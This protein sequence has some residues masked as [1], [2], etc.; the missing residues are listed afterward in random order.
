MMKKL[1]LLLLFSSALFAYAQEEDVFDEDLLDL[2]LEELLNVQLDVSKT[3][4]SLRETPAIIS[5]I[6]RQEIANSGA[7]DLMDVLNLVPGFSFGVDVQNTIGL[8]L[9]GNWGHEGKILL[10]IDGMEMNETLFSTTQF[11]QHYNVNNIERIEIIRGPGSSIYGGYAELGV[12][13][14]ITRKG[15]DIE[16][17]RVTGMYGFGEGGTYRQVGSFSLGKSFSSGSFSLYGDY[18]SAQRSISDY[19]DA[20]GA[21]TNLTDQ[22]RLRPAS[23]GGSLILGDLSANFLYDNYALETVDQFGDIEPMDVVSFRTFYSNIKYKKEINEKLTVT[24]A[25]N[26]KSGI[27]WGVDIATP[28]GW[29]SDDY[30]VYYHIQT[31]RLAPSLLVN[32]TISENADLLIGA[33]SYFDNATATTDD[34]STDYFGDSNSVKYS[35]IGAFAQSVIKTDFAN[36][37]L[38]ARVDN[39][40]AVGSAFS[41]RIGLT[42]E[43]DKFN[44]KLLYSRAFRAPAIENI[45]YNPDI[46]PEKT[47][48][49]ELELGYQLNENSILSLNVFNI[50]IKDPIVYSTTGNAGTYD[51]FTQ[52]GTNGAEIEYKYNSDGFNLTLNYAMYTSKGINEVDLYT[53][54]G[55]DKSVLGLPSSR[56]NGLANIKINDHFSIN[57]SFNFIG[58]TYGIT[59][60]DGNLNYV[61]EQIDPRFYANIFIRYNTGNLNIGLGLNDLLDQKALFIQ[62]YSSGHTPINGLGREFTLKLSYKLGF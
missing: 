3:N 28:F 29:N 39:H 50:N 56:I 12:I 24:P 30:N 10:L 17:V 2:S 52:A 37:T 31:T 48:V 5:V 23:L 55:E 59:S 8:G 38:G 40:S 51:N 42:K 13:N 16:G 1:L 61:F 44:F 41:P 33:D 26:F 20:T 9:R 11:G 54:P 34:G 27:P 58:S 22:A 6:N 57:P 62:P 46:T 19:T 21:V 7:R 43:I 49:A 32:Y 45:G 4:L 25:I 60:I 53:I 18:G 14:I 35:N 36:L 47:G 15:S